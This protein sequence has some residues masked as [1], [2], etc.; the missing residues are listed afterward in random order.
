MH[1]S[2]MV[3]PARNSDRRNLRPACDQ[4]SP[5]PCSD[6]FRRD[7]ALLSPVRALVLRSDQIKRTARFRNA[8]AAGLLPLRIARGRQ[9][10]ITRQYER[11]RGAAFGIVHI[12]QG[13][14]SLLME[15][16]QMI[17]ATFNAP[18]FA[19]VAAA[20]APPRRAASGG[21]AGLLAGLGGAPAIRC[22]STGEFSATAA[23]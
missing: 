18:L 14:D 10:N 19:L 5:H 4:A 15:Y 2:A 6:L 23:A 3:H 12:A 16:I 20:A 7:G 11:I 22:S 13:A 8:H 17:L 1:R 9:P 21:L